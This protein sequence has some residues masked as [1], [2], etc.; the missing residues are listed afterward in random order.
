MRRSAPARWLA[1]V[2]IK[3]LTAAK[4]RLRGAVPDAVH[5]ELVLAMAQ[6]TVAAALACDA[7]TVV[8]VVCDD[9]A[10]REALAAL[11]AECVP[12]RPGAGLNAAVAFGA[13]G[14]R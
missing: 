1:V 7:V 14:D 3:P 13:N 9:P 10:V 6:D 5:A 12:D 8:R 11:G 2:P 4:T